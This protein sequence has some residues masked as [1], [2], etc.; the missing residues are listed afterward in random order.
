MKKVMLSLFT[1]LSFAAFAGNN[2]K[3]TAAMEKNIKVLYESKTVDQ[4]LN[5]ANSFERIAQSESAEWLPL[6][7]QAYANLM[8]GM[9]QT[10]NNLKDEYFDKALTILDKAD[11]ISKDNSEIYVLKSWVTS[12]KIGIDPQNRGMEMGMMAGM[13]LQKATS[14][15]AE[16]PRAYL[17]KAMSLMYTPE[18]YGGG[19]SKAIPVFE[20]AIEK[21]KT[22]K[23]SSTIMP[24]WGKET[25]DKYY[26][27]C[28]K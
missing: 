26:I 16:N 17:M 18:Q 9:Q 15:D 11:A 14:F 25:A 1:L 12:M 27:E 6:Y 24:D 19:K 10:Q 7:Y 13:Y 23:P 28:K 21:F 3:Y 20:T 8:T 2:A 5:V 22:F 4:Y